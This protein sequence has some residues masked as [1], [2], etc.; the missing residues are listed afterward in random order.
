[1]NL[2]KEDWILIKQ[3]LIQLDKQGNFGRAPN[4]LRIKLEQELKN[5]QTSLREQILKLEKVLDKA[6]EL[7]IEANSQDLNIF[8]EVL[9]VDVYYWRTEKYEWKALLEEIAKNENT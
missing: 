9:D 7:L 5:K 8:A 2:T 3:G 6:C 4:D 1:M